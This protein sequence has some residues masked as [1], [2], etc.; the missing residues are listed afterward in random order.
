MG[1]VGLLLFLLACDVVVRRQPRFAGGWVHRCLVRSRG[2]IVVLLVGIV[3][4]L[5]AAAIW[6]AVR[7]NESPAVPAG[8]TTSTG[9]TEWGPLSPFVEELI[10]TRDPIGRRSTSVKDGP[11]NR[12]F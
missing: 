9:V 2:A 1:A 8:S 4:S 7:S 6:D 11:G 5:V 3:A 10:T 12:P